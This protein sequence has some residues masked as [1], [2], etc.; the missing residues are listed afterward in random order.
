MGER[1]LSRNGECGAG[2]AIPDAIGSIVVL[3]FRGIS[4][5]QLNFRLHRPAWNALA[6]I[7]AAIALTAASLGFCFAFCARTAIPYSSQLQWR[8][9]WIRAGRWSGDRRHGDHLRGNWQ[10]NG[11]TGTVYRLKPHNGSWILARTSLH[12]YRRGRRCGSANGRHWSRWR[13]LWQYAHWWTAQLPRGRPG[14][15]GHFP[16]CNHR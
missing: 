13:P 6:A 12:V 11:R 9:R 16:S 5:I 7:R 1:F 8:K 2:P 10:A 4:M 15:W 3:L 14:L